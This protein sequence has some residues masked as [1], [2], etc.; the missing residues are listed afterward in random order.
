MSAGVKMGGSIF[1]NAVRF[2][3]KQTLQ[4][5]GANRGCKH[6]VKTEGANKGCKHVVHSGANT[7]K[8]QGIVRK[9]SSSWTLQF[10][11]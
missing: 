3:D 8:K 5:E 10:S 2:W 11:I 6:R 1:P 4:T 9:K 7:E